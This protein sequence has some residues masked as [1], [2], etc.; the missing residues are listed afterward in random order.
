MRKEFHIMNI[1]ELDIDDILYPNELRKTKKPPKKL[2]VL[3]NANILNNQC[4]SIVGSRCCTDYGA[5]IAR[6]FASKI[7][8]R[9]ITIVS[10]MA[11]GIDSEAHLGAIEAGGKTI[12]VLRFWI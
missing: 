12:A 1:Q 7:A 5:E 6:T 8:Q 11:K 4:L 2:Y 3:G 10:G 9:G